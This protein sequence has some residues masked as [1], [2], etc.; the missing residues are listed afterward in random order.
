LLVVL[1]DTIKLVKY[2]NINTH[3]DDF[4]QIIRNNSAAWSYFVFHGFITI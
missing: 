3:R 4:I 1:T 2:I